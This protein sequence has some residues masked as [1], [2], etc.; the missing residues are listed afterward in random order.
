MTTMMCGRWRV[1]SLWRQ[2]ST[3]IRQWVGCCGP[4]H[5]GDERGPRWVGRAV[6]VGG[7]RDESAVPDPLFGVVVG[8]PAGEVGGFD[9]RHRI[10]V[11]G[12]GGQFAQGVAGVEAQV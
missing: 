6:G 5:G 10:E 3:T 4:V 7:D 11:A 2:M 9:E 1:W 8:P 12:E